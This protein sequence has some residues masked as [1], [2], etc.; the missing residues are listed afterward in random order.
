MNTA[1]SRLVDGDAVCAGSVAFEKH[2]PV[3]ERSSRWNDAPTFERRQHCMRGDASLNSISKLSCAIGA[4]LGGSAIGMTVADT[5]DSEGIQE[6]V[7][8]AQRCTEN[9]Q[10]VPITIQA[11]T[12]ETLRQLNVQTFDDLIKYTPNVTQASTGPGEASIFMRGLSVGVTSQQ[13]TGTSGSIPNVAVYL[14]E[15]SGALTGRNLDVYAADLGRVE[16]LRAPREP[17]SAPASRPASCAT[18]PTNPSSM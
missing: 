15:Q 16:V 13:G 2:D 18:S 11:L 4:I 8:T 7:V 10:D 9:A 14:D 3:V 12:S 1:M 6:I 5:P 17:C